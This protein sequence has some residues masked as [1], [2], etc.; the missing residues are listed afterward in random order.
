MKKLYL[1]IIV[2]QF[3]LSCGNIKKDI[4]IDILQDGQGQYDTSCYLIQNGDSSLLYKTYNPVEVDTVLLKE[5]QTFYV[6]KEDLTTEEYSYEYFIYD[7]TNDILYG[8]SIFAMN[9]ILDSISSNDIETIFNSNKRIEY[10]ADNIDIKSNNLRI[11]YKVIDKI[12]YKF[13]ELTKL[14]PPPYIRP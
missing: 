10:K 9:A 11:P 7:A 4:A 14:G 2:S 13:L 1:I 8:S 12:K 5:G 3:F 6:L